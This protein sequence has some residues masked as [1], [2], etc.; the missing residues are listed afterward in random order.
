MSEM[1]F[2]VHSVYVYRYLYLIQ[3]PFFLCCHPVMAF[4]I[5]LIP[6]VSSWINY[7]IYNLRICILVVIWFSFNVY[8][9]REVD[10]NLR[11]KPVLALSDSSAHIID[12]EST[13]GSTV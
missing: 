12:Y 10:V 4:Y 11:N 7:D 6:S 13:D 3:F 8:T 9:R 1:I 5:L 2:M